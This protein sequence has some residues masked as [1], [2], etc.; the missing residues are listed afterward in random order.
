MNA[1]LLLIPVSLLLVA[2]A[3][4]IFFWAVRH[5]QF[6]DLDTPEILPLLD[7]DDPAE[8]DAATQDDASDEAKE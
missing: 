8:T 4:A 1:L 7:E 5:H 2:A 6:D 3:A